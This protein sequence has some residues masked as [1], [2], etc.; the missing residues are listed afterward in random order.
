MTASSRPTAVWQIG[1]VAPGVRG[2]ASA[3]VTIGRRR[4]GTASSALHRGHRT[5]TPVCD[6]GTRTRAP[7][8]HETTAGMDCDPPEAHGPRPKATHARVSGAMR[9]GD[10]QSTLRDRT[11]CFVARIVLSGRSSRSRITGILLRQEQEGSAMAGPGSPRLTSGT[12]RRSPGR[13]RRS[14]R[15]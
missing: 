13:S 7:H 11:T 5:E 12:C 4:T 8:S 6:S 3:D 10:S 1:Q 14:L 9:N 15:R 2:P